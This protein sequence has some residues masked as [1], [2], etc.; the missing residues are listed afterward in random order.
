MGGG[1][2]YSRGQFAAA[3]MLLLNSKYKAVTKQQMQMQLSPSLRGRQEEQLNSGA[4]VLEA[5]VKA[6][7]LSLQ[8]HSRWAVDTPD[9]SGFRQ[10]ATI[11]TAYSTVHVHC[12]QQLRSEL[13]DEAQYWEKRR[14]V[15]HP[16]VE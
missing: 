12:M 10:G 11:I 14:K 13:E 7:M 5:L 9:E 15:C 8:R 16:S 1:N 3:A 6:N 4:P 2:G